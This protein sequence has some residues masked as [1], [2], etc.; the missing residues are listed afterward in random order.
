MKIQKTLMTVGVVSTLLVNTFAQSTIRAEWGDGQT[1]P[2]QLDID[3]Y[4]WLNRIR[5][6]P[7]IIIPDLEKMLCL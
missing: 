4:N 7:T 6:D 3:A 2:S 5:M 1:A